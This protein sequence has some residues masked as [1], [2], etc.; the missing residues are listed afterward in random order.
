[1]ADFIACGCLPFAK[2]NDIVNVTKRLNGGTI[3]L[4]QR[5]QWFSKWKTSNA[6][7]G[8]SVEKKGHQA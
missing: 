1:V 7:M 2:A 4:V 8:D 3:G 6:D 5:I